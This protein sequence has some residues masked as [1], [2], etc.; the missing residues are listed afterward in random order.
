MDQSGHLQPVA[1]E[2][3]AV[4]RDL[5]AP[6]HDQVALL[7]RAL[8]LTEEMHRLLVERLASERLIRQQSWARWMRD[9]GEFNPP[10]RE[11]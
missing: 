10:F 6:D 4:M 11:E 5:H 2:L 7:A 3:H 8:Q 1:E 9:V